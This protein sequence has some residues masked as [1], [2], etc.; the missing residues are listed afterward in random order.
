MHD[1]GHTVQQPMIGHSPA[2]YK[3]WLPGNI[4]TRIRPI[5]GLLL[6]QLAP[7]AFAADEEQFAAYLGDY[8]QQSHTSCF[9]GDNNEMTRCDVENLLTIER[10]SAKSYSVSFVVYGAY[11]HTCQMTGEARA[12]AGKLE[13][14]YV[15]EKPL[16]GELSCVLT[17]EPDDLGVV[18]KADQKSGCKYW[19]CG[20]KATFDGHR[21]Y[22]REKVK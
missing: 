13:H 2:L 8:R 12:S 16:G 5:A 4:M 1:F 19:Y 9:V 17:L 6:V 15:A 21:F 18:L 11:S 22:L 3:R 20:Q 10:K 7:V 14:H